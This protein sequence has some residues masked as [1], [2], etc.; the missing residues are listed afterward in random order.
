MIAPFGCL[1]YNVLMARGRACVGRRVLAL[2]ATISMVTPSV[3]QDNILM[4]I[5]DDIGVDRVGVYDAHPSPGRTPNI[6]LLAAQGVL[7]RNAWS[8]PTC[9]PSRALLLTGRYGFR[10][11]IGEIIRENSTDD[12][13][14]SLAELS[15]PDLLAP[16][17][18]TAALGKW[19]L[20]NS[21]S[22]G[23]SHPLD[24]GFD[25]HAGSIHNLRNSQPGGPGPGGVYFDFDKGVNGTIRRSTTYATTD[26][27]DDAVRAMQSLPEPWFIWLAF[28]A[29]HP[30]FHKPPAHLHTYS[31]P[32]PPSESRVAHMKAMTQA[33]D[34]EMGRMLSH[35]DYSET[36]II[37]LGDNG[38][39]SG[40]TSAPYDSNHA[41]STLYQGG[42]H[43][44]L[45]IAGSR[46]TQAGSECP[47]LVSLTDMYATISE[48]AGY[49][50]R[51]RDGVS[52]LPYLSDPDMPSI[53]DFLYAELFAPNGPHP[54]DSFERAIR[55]ERYKLIDRRLLHEREFYDLL[56]D[57]LETNDLFLVGLSPAEAVALNELEHKLT[58]L[59]NTR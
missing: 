53:R 16:T 14:L 27:V 59:W 46:V 32:A 49:G 13:G 35:V 30:P 3:A 12:P 33:M 5:A 41:K 45:I 26:T 29:P 51:A 50:G 6:D 9:S 25:Y 42:V 38:T 4:I 15:L 37:F 54:Y 20:G 21:Y 44:P 52:V 23:P 24:S 1:G 2:V 11:G 18:T 56:L 34:T 31:L 40:A 48:I 39:A 10:T 8:N 36:T 22:Q 28:N 17:Y 55:D 7:F 47:A 43:V 57:P 19:H 58:R